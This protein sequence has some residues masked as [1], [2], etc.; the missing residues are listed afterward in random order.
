MHSIGLCY[1]VTCTSDTTAAVSGDFALGRYSNSTVQVQL[2]CMYNTARA[3]RWENKVRSLAPGDGKYEYRIDDSGRLQLDD[4]D[5]NQKV[6]VRL[7]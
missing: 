1:P 2:Q 7:H 4:V 3:A 5:A 6:G